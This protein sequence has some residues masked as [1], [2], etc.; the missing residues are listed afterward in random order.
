MQDYGK[1]CPGPVPTSE[2]LAARAT[3]PELP[4]PNVPVPYDFTKPVGF[5]AG[6]CNAYVPNDNTLSR[7]LWTIQYFVANGFYVVVSGCSLGPQN[8]KWLVCHT[9]RYF[10]GHFDA[11]LR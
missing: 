6:R 9:H 7:L 4:R 8:G 5:K 1:P 2:A 3:N 11:W 10:S